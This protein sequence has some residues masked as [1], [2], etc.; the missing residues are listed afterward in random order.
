MVRSAVE[1]G[2]EQKLKCTL[3]RGHLSTLIDNALHEKDLATQD[4]LKCS[5]CGKFRSS[6]IQKRNFSDR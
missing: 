5:L 1:G 6:I 3:M 4:K 2:L